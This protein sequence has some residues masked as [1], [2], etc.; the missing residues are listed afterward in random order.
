MTLFSNSVGA[1]AVRSEL[2][3]R[4]IPAQVPFAT[5]RQLSPLELTTSDVQLHFGLLVMGEYISANAVTDDERTALLSKVNDLFHQH[6]ARGVHAAAEWTLRRAGVVPAIRPSSG[7]DHAQTSLNHRAS[8]WYLSKP[9]PIA[10]SEV[11]DTA[12]GVVTMLIFEPQEFQMGSPVDE[13]GRWDGR[14][15]QSENLHVRRIPH[16]F[17]V[18]SHEVSLEQFRSFRPDHDSS[19]FGNVAR[20]PGH[21]ISWYEA[22]AFCNWLSELDGIPR[23][24]WCYD[25]DQKFEEGLKPL[26][27]YLSRTGYRLPTEAEWEC[28]CRAGTTSPWFFGYSE[29]LITK[30]G[31]YS[32]KFS[33]RQFLP[34]GFLKPNEAG[35]FDVYCNVSEWCHDRY[36]MWPNTGTVL[37]LDEDLTPL[38]NDEARVLRGGSITSSAE[39]SRSAS[40]RAL[41]PSDSTDAYGIRVFRT[42]PEE[43]SRNA[44]TRKF[45][46]FVK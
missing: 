8:E 27:G 41:Y 9:L 28:V 24:Q 34:C 21:R 12:D 7:E 4:L 44:V 22:A 11:R 14:E 18:S 16:R 13:K 36:L 20:F 2:L 29:R 6:P 40:R 30:Y 25:P 39:T 45:E 26:E 38:R 43:F 23:D 42:L 31:S 3:H 35:L 32:E 46:A 19:S 33:E 17:A 15:G 5:A 1:T 37:G 10:R